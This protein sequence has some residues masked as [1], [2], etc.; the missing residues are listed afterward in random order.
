M[1]KLNGLFE[2]NRL[3]EQ[4]HSVIGGQGDWTQKYEDTGKDANGNYDINFGTV[5]EFGG[6]SRLDTDV[7]YDENDPNKDRPMD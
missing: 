4:A 3:N 1:E 6:S 7:T 5:D 2:A